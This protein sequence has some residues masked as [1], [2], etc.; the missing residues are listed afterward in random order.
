MYHPLVSIII[1]TRNR[2][3]IL[4]HA[5]SSCISQ[6]YR[7][8][9]I[10]VVDDNSSDSTKRVVQEVSKEYSNI[11]YIRNRVHKGLPASR[12][13]GLQYARG[14]LIFFSEDDLILLPNTLEVLVNTYISLSRR[15]KL[16]AVAPRLILVSTSLSYSP[17]PECKKIIGIFNELTGAEHCANY[18]VPSNHILLSAH[19]PATSLIP[20]RVFNDVGT[21]YT[22]YKYNYVYE[23]S[24]LY[25]RLIKS[26]YI[27]IYQ[28]KAIA[29]HV[30]GNPGG[31]T[32]TA[33]KK[34]FL[35]DNYNLLLFN[36][37]MFHLG[38]LPRTLLSLIRRAAR[39]RYLKNSKKLFEEISILDKIGYRYSYW[40]LIKNYVHLLKSI[41]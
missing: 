36:L 2:A 33:L 22:G 31:C 41:Y 24:D 13:I 18:D 17:I 37:R 4:K 40:K 9:E 15:L 32:T 38:G 7:N 35:A 11:V 29:Y 28:P 21:Y 25:F 5:I 10:I 6:T 23:D 39:V 8:V 34:Y 1:P 16:G 14:E 26:G 19:P 20:K 30:S 3:Y 12:N 27:L